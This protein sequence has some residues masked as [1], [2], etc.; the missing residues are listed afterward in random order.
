MGG[1]TEAKQAAVD[2][3]EAALHLTNVNGR[4]DGGAHIHADVRA[5]GLEVPSQGV[6]LNL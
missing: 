5:Q 4:V 3:D 6:Q 1:N 2:L